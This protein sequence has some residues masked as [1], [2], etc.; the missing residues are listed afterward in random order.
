MPDIG[1]DAGECHASDFEDV[2]AGEGD[3]GVTSLCSRE[4]QCEDKRSSAGLLTAVLCFSV[5]DDWESSWSGAVFPP[6]GQGFS[7]P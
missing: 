6:V 2:G 7:C 1:E 3:R 4:E 5:N